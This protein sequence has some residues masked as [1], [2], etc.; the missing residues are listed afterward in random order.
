MFLSKE[1]LLRA[2]FYSFLIV[3]GNFNQEKKLFESIKNEMK[4]DKSLILMKEIKTK[5]FSFN[6]CKISVSLSKKNYSY[7]NL[8]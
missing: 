7:Q 6:I 8:F 2:C 3:S 4:Y 1:F 5:I